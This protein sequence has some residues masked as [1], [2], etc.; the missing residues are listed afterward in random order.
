M[1]AYL[2]YEML[3][4]GRIAPVIIGLLGLLV[5]GLV[6]VVVG[7]RR[8]T[9]RLAFTVRCQRRWIAFFRALAQGQAADED[10]VWLAENQSRMTVELGAADRI[11]YRAPYSQ[12]V[13]SNYP[14]LTNTLAEAR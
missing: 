4:V 12:Y 10:Y 9:A 7:V 2:L 13:V 6:D 5:I 11:D 1:R 3:Y 8:L 14:A